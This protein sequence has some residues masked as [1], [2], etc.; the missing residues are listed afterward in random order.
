MGASRC[1]FCVILLLPILFGWGS[2]RAQEDQL[3]SIEVTPEETQES[4]LGEVEHSEFTGSHTHIDARLAERR[5]RGLAALVAEEAGVQFR[6]A[7]G[8]GSYSSISIRAASSAQTNVFFDGVLL[9][10]ASNGGVD[11]S[12]LDL[13]TVDSVDIY[14]AATPIQ[15]GVGAI[16]GA[17]NLRSRRTTQNATSVRASLGSFGSSSLFL[18]HHGELASWNTVAAVSARQSDNTFEF[19]NG[20]G[21]PLTSN[22]DQRQRRFNGRFNRS[23]L[24]L[25]SGRE[26]DAG[27]RYD[28]MLQI[29]DRA[30]GVP[31]WLNLKNNRA[32]YDTE[33]LQFQLNRR[34]T[35]LSDEGWSNSS[36]IFLNN[37]VEGYD[38]R[39]GQIGLGMQLATADTQVFGARSYWEN[40]TETGTVAFNSELRFE[41][42]DQQDHLENETDT[43]SRAQLDLALQYSL[44]ALDDRLLL[45]PALRIQS[46]TDRYDGLVISGPS[47]RDNTHLSPQFGLRW[48]QSDT[49]SVNLNIGQH[50]REPVFFELFGDRGLYI[51]S[52]DLV[53]ERGSNMDIGVSWQSPDDDLFKFGGTLTGFLSL[54][55]EIIVATFD[56]RRIGRSENTGK[57]RI[58]GIEATLD[59]QLPSLWQG[60]FRFTYQS[61]KNLSRISGFTNNQ[62]PGEAQ[63]AAFV[64]LKRSRTARIFK[65]AV[66]ADLWIEFDL[67]RD[68]FFDAANLLKAENQFTQNVG[69]KLGNSAGKKGLST[70]LQIN[71]LSNQSTQDFNGF[72][73]PGR[74][75]E[76]T[77]NYSL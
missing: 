14:R 19:I 64:R 47:S 70:T 44:F 63:T 73:K 8:V 43:A 38:D 45:A 67:L 65:R 3:Q 18:A 51:G 25:K 2:L 49:L 15:L 71:N 56:S 29:S 20:G 24:L 21:T 77:L 33:T 36:G 12:Q 40:V 9:N 17:V 41:S 72:Y 53:A 22:D 7:G 31:H 66:S 4:R 61:A 26:F 62:L 1:Q 52:D 54:R 27:L 6:Q 30:Q 42:L 69:I 23:A 34:K 68:R 48:D 59:W 55:D 32:S 57:A 16:G 13:L 5:G 50:H 60:S 37:T 39:L 74:N 28:A 76:V 10:N 46:L 58:A 11:F 75:F 35:S